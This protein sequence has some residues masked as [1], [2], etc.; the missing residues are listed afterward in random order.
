MSLVRKIAK[1]LLTLSAS[2]RLYS[3]IFGSYKITYKM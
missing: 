3:L 1:K 2:Q